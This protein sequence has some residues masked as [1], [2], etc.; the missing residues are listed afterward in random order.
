[1]NAVDHPDETHT[2]TCCRLST[3]H[4][5]RQC[6]P[7]RLSNCLFNNLGPAAFCAARVQLRKCS[8]TYRSSHV[9]SGRAALPR[10]ALQVPRVRG[11]AIYIS[12]ESTPARRCSADI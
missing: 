10:Q 5:P 4:W 8:V 11:A 7:V 12:S 3:R 6:W 2:T 9:S 1:M